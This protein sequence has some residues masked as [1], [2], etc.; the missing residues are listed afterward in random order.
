MLIF[1]LLSFEKQGLQ[2][3]LA[4]LN[5]VTRT[6]EDL[7]TVRTFIRRRATS[8]SKFLRQQSQ[9]C[10]KVVFFSPGYVRAQ[11]RLRASLDRRLRRVALI[12]DT[13]VQSIQRCCL[14]SE[15][16]EFVDAV[17][18]GSSEKSIDSHSWSA[19]WQQSTPGVFL[20]FVQTSIELELQ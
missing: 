16:K 14:T 8:L 4:L 20:R 11:S 19:R 5:G 17:E 9:L 15:D 18:Q 1:G 3:L 6:V 13:V 2:S 12:V 10:A 7:E